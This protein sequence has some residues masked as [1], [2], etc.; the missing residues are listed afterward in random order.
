MYVCSTPACGFLVGLP[1]LEAL[2]F[3]RRVNAETGNPSTP[4][5]FISHNVLY[6]VVNQLD[7][8]RRKR[9]FEG[10]PPVVKMLP[11]A[12]N[13]STPAIRLPWRSSKW[14]RTQGRIA[15]VCGA[16]QP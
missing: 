2:A 8:G 9:S 4:S 10:Q 1:A 15:C 6:Q 3:G 12:T 11:A 7:R 16:L 5:L 14:L 13:T